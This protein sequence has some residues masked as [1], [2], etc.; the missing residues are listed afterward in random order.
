MKKQ[1]AISPEALRAVLGALA[2]GAVGTAT[3]YEVTPRLGGYEDVESARRSA[4]LM[5][6]LTGAMAGGLVGAKGLRGAM[7]AMPSSL[8]W[9]AGPALLAEEA[10]PMGLATMKRTQ[11][12]AQAQA[13][14]A[15]ESGIS[16]E[17]SKAL[18]SGAGRGAV[19]GASLAGLAG[20][21]SGLSRRQSDEEFK[22]RKGRTSMIGADTLKYLLPLLIGGGLVGSVVDKYK[23]RGA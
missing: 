11:E 7:K 19:A 13:N 8:R 4:G 22:K 16:N 9:S 6:G 12:T 15:R 5:H 17:V 23:H 10:L 18:T 2:G 20:I 3:G 1:A 21:I 14:A